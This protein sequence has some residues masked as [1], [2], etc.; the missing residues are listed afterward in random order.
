M[1]NEKIR[2][3][4]IEHKERFLG[5]RNLI[6]REVQVEIARFL[7]QREIILVTG[8]RRSG[9]SSLLRLICGDLLARGDIVP[10]DILYLNFDDERFSSFTVQD[11]APG[12]HSP[13]RSEDPA[14]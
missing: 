12:L 9:K 5:R 4:I 10:A 2:E 6:R 8:V 13:H 3:L 1:E 14:A 7:L 11:F